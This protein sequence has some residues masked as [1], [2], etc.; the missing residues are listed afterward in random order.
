MDKPESFGFAKHQITPFN[1][2]TPDG[3]TLYAWHVLPLNVYAKHRESLVSGHAGDLQEWRAAILSR[4]TQDSPDATVV[5]DE[6]EGSMKVK[7]KME[8]RDWEVSISHTPSVESSKAAALSLRLL[9]EDPDA[10]VVINCKWYRLDKIECD[11]TVI[12]SGTPL[13]D[14]PWISQS[15][16]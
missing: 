5:E 8:N 11:C 13:S 3:E 7:T 12:K 10:R 2:S 1:I 4:V 9:K 15:L 16:S 6:T 14:I